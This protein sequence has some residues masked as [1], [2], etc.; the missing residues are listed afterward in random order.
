M[1]RVFAVLMLLIIAVTVV[2]ADERRVVVPVNVS[3]FPIYGFSPSV[4][5]VNNIQLNI[6]VGYADELNGAAVGVVSIIGHSVRGTQVNVVNLAGGPVS[7]AQ[8]GVLNLSQREVNGTQIGVVNGSLGEIRGPQVGVVNTSLSEVHGPQVGVVNTA[9]QSGSQIGVVN[10][11]VNA[12]GVQLG[13]VN[14]AVRNTGAPVGVVSVVLHGGQTHV[15]SWI[16][17]TGLVSVGL[18]HGSSRTYN[19]YTAATDATLEKVALGLGLGVH[20]GG[21]RSWTRVETIGSSI[22]PAGSVFGSGPGLT[23]FC[24]RAYAGYE[25]GPVALIAGVSFNY[26]MDLTD[27]EVELAPLHGYEFPFST[28][29]HRFWPGAFVGIQL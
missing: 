23:L 3:F 17:E 28:D 5:V 2:S 6:V 16:D 13:V 19:I 4:T 27:A 8:I 1:K 7:G 15:E 10:A 29:R 12:S 21:E 26:L 24:T 22:N 25:F 11:S 9:K 14:V 20:F 18:I